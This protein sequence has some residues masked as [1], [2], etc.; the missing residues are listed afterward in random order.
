MTIL[1]RL[2]TP[3]I[4]FRQCGVDPEPCL[5]RTC[6]EAMWARMLDIQEVRIAESLIACQELS[7]G[8]LVRS[9]LIPENSA[10]TEL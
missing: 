6:S 4:D 8:F 3:P 10:R 9:T 2:R 7:R 1:R 5:G